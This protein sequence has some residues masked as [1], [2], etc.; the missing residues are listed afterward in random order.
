MA[1]SLKS[2]VGK[3]PA[4]ARYT[5]DAF[6]KAKIR[7]QLAPGPVVL[8]HDVRLTSPALQDALAAGLRGVGRDVIDIGLCGTEEVY[9]QTDHLGAAGRAD[10]VESYDVGV[11]T[12]AML[13]VFRAAARRFA[14]RPAPAPALG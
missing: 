7:H 13:D 5:S 14:D 11:C 3:P 4:I 8:G 12:E 10:V 9:F 1:H 6:A 2:R